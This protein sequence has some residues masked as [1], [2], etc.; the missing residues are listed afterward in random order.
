MK[1]DRR[2]EFQLY[3]WLGSF[4]KNMRHLFFRMSAL[5]ARILGQGI[6]TKTFE[7]YNDYIKLQKLKTEDPSR[8]KLWLGIEWEEKL[9]VFTSYFRQMPEVKTALI[10]DTSCALCIGA[11]TGQEVQALKDLGYNAIGLDLVPHP[12]LVVEGDMHN[13]PFP[14][15][16]FNMIFSNCFDHSLLPEVFIAEIERVASEKCLIILLVQLNKIDDAFGVTDLFDYK[17]LLSMFKQ[18]TLLRAQ[19]IE[20]MLGMNFEIILTRD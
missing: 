14:N 1:T 3:S 18:S 13:M 10:D 20:D 9:R 16:K 5:Q 4:K 12:P 19:E 11:R 6:S 7:T 2:L 8:R 15:G 17:A